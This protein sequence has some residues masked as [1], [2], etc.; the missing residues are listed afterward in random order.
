LITKIRYRDGRDSNL[1]FVGAQ[2]GATT[3]PGEYGRLFLGIND[4]YLRDNKGSFKVV[5]RW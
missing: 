1:L 5:I 2:G 3:D 4:D